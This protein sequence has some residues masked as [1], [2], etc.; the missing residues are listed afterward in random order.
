MA[1]SP[2]DTNGT[3]KKIGEVRFTRRSGNYWKRSTPNLVEPL[4]FT[5]SSDVHINI[6]AIAP[7]GRPQSL[8]Q[9]DCFPHYTGS[10][11]LRVT[12]EGY[13]GG[14]YAWDTISLFSFTAY[15]VSGGSNWGRNKHIEQMPDRGSS[16]VY[17]TWDNGWWRFRDERLGHLTLRVLPNGTGGSSVLLR[18]SFEN[19]QG[20]AAMFNVVGDITWPLRNIKTISINSSDG[21]GVM[22]GYAMTKVY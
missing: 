19:T 9:V 11:N 7:R 21:S 10:G 2:T 16:G 3:E 4:K 13:T 20:Q 22:S 12:F 18:S 8:I 6:G 1:L 15:L 5:A 17:A 14:W